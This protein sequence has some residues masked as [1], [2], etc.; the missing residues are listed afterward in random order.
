MIAI[1]INQ[2]KLK[3]FGLFNMPILKLILFFKNKSKCNLIKSKVIKIYK[4][5]IYLY[6]NKK[7]N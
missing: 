6:M 1:S 2:S 5:N 7:K 3:I 4:K